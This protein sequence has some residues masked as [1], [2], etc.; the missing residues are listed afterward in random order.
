MWKVLIWLSSISEG[1]VAVILTDLEI[2]GTLFT[3]GFS[4][5]VPTSKIVALSR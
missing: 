5:N 1:N 2:S 3:S 4:F